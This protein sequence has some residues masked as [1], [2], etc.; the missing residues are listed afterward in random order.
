MA[1]VLVDITYS[2]SFESSN[3]REGRKHSHSFATT[4][5]RE[6]T[7]ELQ[8]TDGVIIQ[9]EVVNDSHDGVKQMSYSIPG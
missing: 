5:C 2:P 6:N 7:R 9:E 1:N 3:L 8:V 4:D